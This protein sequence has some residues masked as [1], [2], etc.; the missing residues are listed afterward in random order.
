M[1]DEIKKE[2]DKLL[3]EG[4]LPYIEC[5]SCSSRFFYP[6]EFCPKC[7]FNRFK[8]KV[9][10]GV[11]RVFSFTRF[12]GKSGTVVYAIIELEEGFRM[13]SNVLDDVNI[14]DKVKVVFK[15]KIPYFIKI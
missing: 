6:K 13:Y 7:G 8:V 3:S 5:E 2:Y 10:S 1:I 11:G 4:R 14:N 9:S 12:Q 15:G